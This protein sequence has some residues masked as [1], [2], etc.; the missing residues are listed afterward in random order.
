MVGFN[1][2]FERYMRLTRQTHEGKVNVE[3]MN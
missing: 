3:D 1:L 2:G